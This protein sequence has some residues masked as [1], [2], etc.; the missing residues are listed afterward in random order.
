MS[1]ISNVYFPIL[2]ADLDVPDFY[3]VIFEGFAQV[4]I[5]LGLED[6][7]PMVKDAEGLW[8]PLPY[9]SASCS[10]EEKEHGLKDNAVVC[11]CVITLADKDILER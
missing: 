11:V 2:K 7:L 4:N 8:K 1:D 6:D 3:S 5:L 10:L 9:P